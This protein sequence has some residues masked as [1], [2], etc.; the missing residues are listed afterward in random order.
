MIIDLMLS[1]FCSK[2]PRA[3]YSR[4]SRSVSVSSRSR[5]GSS[6]RSLSRYAIAAFLF[7]LLVVILRCSIRYLLKFVFTLL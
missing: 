3:K 6:P 4:H 5:A 7:L 1:S 2:S